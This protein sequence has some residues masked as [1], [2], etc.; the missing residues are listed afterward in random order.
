ME[1]TPRAVRLAFPAA[2]THQPF[3]RLIKIPTGLQD[4]AS[5]YGVWIECKEGSIRIALYDI[6][7]MYLAKT[8]TQGPLKAEA[9]DA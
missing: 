1:R 6:H 3:V 7:G 2:E 5:L 8:C 9:Y 4:W